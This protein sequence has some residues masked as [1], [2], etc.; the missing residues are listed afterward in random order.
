MPFVDDTPTIAD[1]D[2]VLRKIGAKV[3]A[4]EVHALYLGAQTSTNIALGPQQ[5]LERILGD[6]AVM[7]ENIA[8]ANEYLQVIFGYWNRLVS[9]HQAGDVH[10]APYPLAATPTRKALLGFVTRRRDELTW[11]IRGVDAGGDH[12]I[13]FGQEGDHLF[14]GIAKGSAFLENYRMLLDRDAPADVHERRASRKALL[15]LVATIERIIDDLMAVSDDVRREAI[16]T[17]DANRGRQTDDGARV[18]APA[19]IGRNEQCPCGSG[20]KWKKCCGAANTVQ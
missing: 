20:K 15:E 6:D 19:R 17:F 8:E 11:Y 12:P 5:L 1:L 14:E 18:A 2:H 4:W 7:G 3:T 9:Q 10:L 16:D 13:E